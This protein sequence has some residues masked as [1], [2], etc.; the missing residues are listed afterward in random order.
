MSEL[1]LHK[2]AQLNE[3]SQAKTRHHDTFT[4]P[5]P[6]VGSKVSFHLPFSLAVPLLFGCLLSSVLVFLVLPPG[7]PLVSLLCLN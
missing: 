3:A 7:W 5:P 6:E 1:T 2:K 4:T